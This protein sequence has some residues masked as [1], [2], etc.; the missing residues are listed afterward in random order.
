MRDLEGEPYA[1]FHPD[2]EE[3]E[4][5]LGDDREVME[6]GET[7]IVPEESY[8]DGSGAHR[9]VQ[10]TRV[11]FSVPD[12]VRAVLGVAV[13]VTERKRADEQIKASLKEKEVLLKEIHH[14]VKNNLQVMSS[15]LSLQTQYLNDPDA[16]AKFRVSMDRIKSMALIH[17]KLYRSGNLSRIYFPGYAEDLTHDLV[18][19]YVTDRI[20]EMD[21]RLEPVSFDVDTAMPLGLIINELVSNSLKHAFP[22]TERGTILV[23]LRKEQG[24]LTL[25]IADNGV[26]FPG[27]IDFAETQSLGMQLVVS[28]VEQLDGTITLT[29]DGGTEF[30]I[31]FAAPQ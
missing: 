24:S 26:G 21:L 11:P 19:T 14:R 20:I 5:M 27:D 28:L 29:R 17:D 30:T 3:L 25:T 12:K 1:D 13:D 18:N 6:K 23:A 4:R 2:G 16:L 10:T 7:K 15:L 31:T 8:T 22:D 9:F